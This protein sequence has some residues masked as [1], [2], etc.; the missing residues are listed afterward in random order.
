M[1]RMAVRG[2]RQGLTVRLDAIEKDKPSR[3]KPGQKKSLGGRGTSMSRAGN[4]MPYRTSMTRVMALSC[5]R[6]TRDGHGPFVRA[7]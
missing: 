2:L 4:G 5:R 7:F 3:V 1:P 6:A